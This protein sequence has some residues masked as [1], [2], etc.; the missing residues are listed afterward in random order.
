VKQKHTR[1]ALTGKELRQFLLHQTEPACRAGKAKGEFICAGDGPGQSLEIT[2]APAADGK[3]YI[4]Q[5][6]GTRNSG[7]Y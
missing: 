2:L 5:I 3:L 7:C 4:S 6:D 1:A